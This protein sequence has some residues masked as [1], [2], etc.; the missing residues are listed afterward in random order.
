M[1]LAEEIADTIALDLCGDVRCVK[2]PMPQRAGLDETVRLVEK[3][4]KR[5]VAAQADVRERA[6]LVATLKTG[7][8]E[9][10]KLH[11]HRQRRHYSDT[12]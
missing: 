1:R 2:Y 8:A 9:F 12:G 6:Q 4:G 7:L 10:G 11:R 3:T 5:I